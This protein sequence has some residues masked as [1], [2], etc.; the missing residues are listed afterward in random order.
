ME[1]ILGP[2]CGSWSDFESRYG[3]RGG[4]ALSLGCGGDI[5]PNAEFLLIGLSEFLGCKA[6]A[7]CTSLGKSS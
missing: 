2:D 3:F 5:E 7:R 6:L 1:W 4:V